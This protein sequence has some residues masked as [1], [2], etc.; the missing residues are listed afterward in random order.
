[1][2][3]A[4]VGI[5]AFII[6]LIINKDLLFPNLIINKEVLF[7]KEK[8]SKTY[9]VYRLFIISILAF[10]ISDVLW[11]FL[12][13]YHLMALLYIDTC[14]FFISMTLSVVFF[15][16]FAE[17]YVNKSKR[18]NLA[19]LHSGL[20]I[21]AY[22]IIVIIL[23]SFV[24]FLFKFDGNV[25]VPLLG[26]EILFILQIVLYAIVSVVCIY[27][28][29]T[30]K[31]NPNNNRFL[32]IG[33]FG[34]V[35]AASI[36]GQLYFPLLPLY[37]VGSI[38]S[39]CFIH[40]F[41]VNSEKDS[42]LKKLID[43]LNREKM[44]GKE[45]DYTR[46]LAYIDSLTGAKN[47]HAFVEM[48]TE[49]DEL[50][51]KNDIESFSIVVFD[52]NGL[53]L[54]NDTRGHEYGDEYIKN[55]YEI[56]KSVYQNIEIY[57]FGG[58]E[59]VAILEENAYLNREELMNKF[60]DIIENNINVGKPIISVG[61]NDYNKNSDNTFRKVFIKADQKMYERKKYLKTVEN[62]LI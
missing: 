43:S 16:M 15:S 57:R 60:N 44:T 23:N 14:L 32:A 21:F 47:K 48:E 33:L 52:I 17:M 9:G 55:S 19:L 20:T 58:D 50:I 40:I 53:K 24:P 26:R 27:F 62:K 42:V 6:C 31:I 38:I 11:G 3:Y 30:D 10:F 4:L 8:L 7:P 1:M 46:K 59:F 18:M 39:I 29:F 35:M 25:Y 28:Y 61:M 36:I 51:S 2:Y 45:L 54:I 56:I 13:Q 12:D 41:V 5:C 37:S 49:I 34:F 22:L